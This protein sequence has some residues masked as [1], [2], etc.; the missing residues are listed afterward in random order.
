MIRVTDDL[1]LCFLSEFSDLFDVEHFKKTLRSDVRIVSSL[2]STHLM[3]RQTI[4][5]QIPWDVSPV[6]IRAKY[7]KQV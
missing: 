6:W 3:S 4:E 2:P 1:L 5:N 7:F